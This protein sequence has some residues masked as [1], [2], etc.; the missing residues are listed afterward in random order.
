MPTKVK[1]AHARQVS[2]Y[3]TSNNADPRITYATPKRCQTYA[4]DEID[5]HRKALHQ[6]ALRVE[7]FLSLSDDPQFFV[8]ITVP[9]LESFY[10]SN[11]ASRQLAYDHWHI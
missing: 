11:P 6:I 5:E 4:V 9:D 8:D 1:V 10:W 2:L 3:V 7:K